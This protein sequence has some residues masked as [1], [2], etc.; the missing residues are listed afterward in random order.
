MRGQ[1]S[2]EIIGNPARLLHPLIRDRRSDEFRRAS[3]DE[4]STG[5]WRHARGGPA[6][7]GIWPGHGVFTTNYGTRIARSSLRRFANFHGCQYWSPAMICW[8]L[9]AFG[10][11]L[12]GMLETNTKED[13]G[14]HSELIVLWARE[15]REP[16]EY[17]APSAGGQ[18]PRRIHR[19]D[20]RAQ[21]RGRRASR[22]TCCS[23]G[24]ARD[25]ALAL[26]MM[27]VICAERV[28][29]AAF[30]ARHT[31]GF[32]RLAAHVA[33]YTPAWAAPSHRHCR[34]SGSWHWRAATPRRARR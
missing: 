14:E 6:A 25:T 22:T 4:A 26:A 1:A 16:A 10:L 24:R 29:D 23:S 15:S 28:H 13:M 27:H 5:S 33:A 21:D 2:R 31:V 11:G 30:V 20:R 18:A 19:H 32:E 8:G 34:P 9:G 7:V 3:W 17:R 12:T